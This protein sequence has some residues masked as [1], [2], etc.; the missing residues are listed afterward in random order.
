LY[1]EILTQKIALPKVENLVMAPAT[2][3]GE[4]MTETP[5]QR[6]NATLVVLVRNNEVRKLLVTIKELELRFNN[7]FHY[8]YVFLNNKAFNDDFKNKILGVLNHKDQEVFF[9]KID[10]SDWNQPAFI[11]TQKQNAGVAHM[12]EEDVAYANMISYHNMCRYNSGKF[13]HHSRMANYKYYWRF[14]PGTRYF[15]DIDYDVF[16][17]MAANKKVYGFVINL[18]DIPQSVETLWATTIKFIEENQQYI[19]PNGAFS[20]LTESVQNLHKY[21]MTKGYST[22]HFWS[23]FEIGDMDF[24]RGEAYSKW[25]D[26]LEAAGGFYYERWGDAP[27]HSVGLGL[28][29]DKDSIHWFRDIGYEHPPYLNCPNLDRCQGRCKAGAF[30]RGGNLLGESCLSTWWEKE[31]SEVQRGLY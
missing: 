14:E 15:C 6:E 16:K 28:F 2:Q 10:P 9:E 19:H 17:F 30:S 23:N 20:W 13:Y 12:V 24:Y 26:T 8:P 31:M 11:D 22:C 4:G 5:Y 21:E 7:K 1:H 18:Y 29:A 27:V 3:E 25:F